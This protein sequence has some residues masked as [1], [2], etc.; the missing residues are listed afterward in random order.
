MKVPEHCGGETCR[1]TRLRKVPLDRETGEPCGDLGPPAC[2]CRECPPCDDAS[3]FAGVRIAS[4]NAHY[5]T[6]FDYGGVSRF[7]LVFDRSKPAR[8]KP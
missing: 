2:D 5:T 8:R 4:A 6:P 1:A 3:V 7:R